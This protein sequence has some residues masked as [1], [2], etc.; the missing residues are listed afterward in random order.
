MKSQII[1]TEFL[2]LK[3]TAYSETSLI[4]GG[5]TPNYGQIRLMVKGAR[6][7]GKKKFPQ[8]DLFRLINL[9]C[10][11]RNT[12]L[13][14]PLAVDPL[15]DYRKLATNY[16]AYQTACWLA[17]FA[18]HNIPQDVE[19]SRAFTAMKYAFERLCTAADKKMANQQSLQAVTI[20]FCIVYLDESG[21]LPRYNDEQ[22]FQQ[23]RRLL[24]FGEGKC[25]A[26][27]LSADAWNK[28]YDWVIDKTI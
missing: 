13:H 5:I 4:V 19:H 17:D 26:P 14:I 18:L 24:D 3:K 8:I 11:N 10:R 20:G 27:S 2:V 9:R 21:L 6:Q 22:R 12:D 1:E 28:I 15:A 25:N 23:C 7:L 16:R